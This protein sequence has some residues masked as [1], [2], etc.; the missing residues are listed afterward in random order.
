LSGSGRGGQRERRDVFA[1]LVDTTGNGTARVWV[2]TLNHIMSLY[3]RAGDHAVD[4]AE[5]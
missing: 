1:A 5:V 2:L 4:I 3:E